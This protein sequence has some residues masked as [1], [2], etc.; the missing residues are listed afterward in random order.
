[1][2]KKMGR[3]PK[4]TP[5]RVE[6]ICQALENGE[7]IEMA[8][9]MAG[10]TKPTYYDWLEKNLDF[11]NRVKE[12]KARFEDWQL[13]GILEDARKSLKTLICGCEYDETKTEYEPGEKGLPRIKKQITITKKILPN[14]T[15]VIF[16]LCNRDPENW[17][18]R[19]IQEL[20][21]RIETESKPNIPL[22]KIPDE[23]LAQV[24]ESMSK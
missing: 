23:L 24:I 1:M 15:A 2:A 3:P 4:C 6:K 14:A 17:S 10:I 9:R 7:S 5:E 21:G 22:D 8:A 20:T 16:A 18:N 11:S 19:H 12:A 13:H